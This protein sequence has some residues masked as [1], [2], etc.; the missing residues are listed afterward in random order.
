[1]KYDLHDSRLCKQ[2]FLALG[3]KYSC[4]SC[5]AWPYFAELHKVLKNVGLDRAFNSNNQEWL[6]PF[7]RL[8][9]HSY[10]ISFFQDIDEKTSLYWYRSFKR[11][12]F[13]EKYL[14]KL[15]DFYGSKLKMMA[16]TG[17]LSLNENQARWRASD[18]TCDLCSDGVEDLPHFLFL[19]PTL[20][21]IRLKFYN[22]LEH[23]L[24]SIDAE[25]MW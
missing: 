19:C 25:N 8:S 6:Q 20:Q 4:G 17:C 24:K 21:P 2:V 12:T 15:N 14:C 13:G 3:D 23:K 16:R 7:M 11:S 10:T 9:L 22:Q 5:T 1:M 18:A